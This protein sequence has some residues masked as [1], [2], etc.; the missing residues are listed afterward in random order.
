MFLLLD[1]Y[2][3]LQREEILGFSVVEPQGGRVLEEMPICGLC[4]RQIW[5]CKIVYQDWYRLTGSRNGDG[6]W[7]YG[8][9]FLVSWRFVEAWHNSNLTGLIFSEHNVNSRAS[10]EASWDCP[11][12]K[13]FRAFPQPNFV[14]FRDRANAKCEKAPSCMLCMS[15]R[16][17]SVQELLFEGDGHPDCF[18]PSCLPGWTVVSSRFMG[19][20]E[21]FKLTNFL[22]LNAFEFGT[23]GQLVRY[24]LQMWNKSICW[25][26]AV[27]YDDED[28][29][30]FLL[31]IRDASS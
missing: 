1:H 20:V 14:Q 27:T 31:T 15:S 19:F 7:M 2:S 9:D 12:Q 24:G 23:E 4:R 8:N 5:P 11:T 26:E 25:K 29:Q 3:T 28:L 30:L 16:V 21:T 22:L 13:Y 17:I 18:L 6:T 10:K